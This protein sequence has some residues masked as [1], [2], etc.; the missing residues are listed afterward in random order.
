M[1]L[2]IDIDEYIYKSLKEYYDADNDGLLSEL[3]IAKGIPLK[4]ELKKIRAKIDK[5]PTM[6][7]NSVGYCYIWAKDY[8]IDVLSILDESI[9]ENK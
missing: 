3:A 9:E 4:K 6:S 8:K 5:L 2:I 1:K 7:C